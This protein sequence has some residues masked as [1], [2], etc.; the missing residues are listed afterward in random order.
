M[1][2]IGII[3]AMDI[4][5]DAL[6]AALKNPSS[7]RVSGILFTSGALNGRQ[8]V[9]AVC[10][11]GKVFAAMCAQTMIVKYGADCIINTGVGG[12]LTSELSIGDIAVADSTLQHD[13]DTTPL[14]DP[15]GYIGEI[16]LVRIPADALLCEKILD[17][18]K[19][20]GIK[21]LSG[22]IASGDRFI[23]NAKQKR[24]IVQNFAGMN[25][26]ACEMEGAAIGLVCHM[27]EVPYAVIR[28]VSD[29]LEGDAEVDFNEFKVSAAQNSI[30]V[31]TAVLEE[32]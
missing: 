24:Q 7:E 16:G 31:V 19:R 30:A 18:T 8:V 6:R 10:G 26:I 17:A 2:T 27:N 13:M 20:L 12:S 11:V 28:S 4:E 25:V 29:S 21:S 23:A 32:L 5:I 15:A 14:G 3:G 9:L 22:A 1:N